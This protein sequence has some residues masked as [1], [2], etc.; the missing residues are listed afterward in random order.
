MSTKLTIDE[1]DFII[2]NL[3]F[4]REQE[5]YFDETSVL[6]TIYIEPRNSKKLEVTDDEFAYIIECLEW[7][8][9]LR[10]FDKKNDLNCYRYEGIKVKKEKIKDKF[11]DI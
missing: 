10:L 5:A 1:R 9:Q 11:K 8:M 6:H 2:E 3:E 4:H 7:N